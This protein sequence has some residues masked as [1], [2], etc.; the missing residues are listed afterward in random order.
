M[1][2]PSRSLLCP[3]DPDVGP[4]GFG[5]RVNYL[6][7]RHVFRDVGFVVPTPLR[8]VQVPQP[9]QLLLFGE[10]ETTNAQFTAGASHYNDRRTV[11]N[12]AVANP[13]RGNAPALVRH[14]WGMMA[15][16]ADGHSEWLRMPPYL[17]GTPVP[18]DMLGLADTTDDPMNS[19]WPAN[20]LAKLYLRVR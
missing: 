12:V 3:A 13:I 1:S 11:W 20:P 17:S 14:S 19:L 6:A 10:K 8:G 16:A 4:T 9:H 5:Y 15:T 18:T 2:Q 7:N